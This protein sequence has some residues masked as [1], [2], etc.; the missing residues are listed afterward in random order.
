M[1]IHFETGSFF[2]EFF[3]ARRYSE[4]VTI[5][6]FSVPMTPANKLKN[7]EYGVTYADLSRQMEPSKNILRIKVVPYESK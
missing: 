3:V 5:L 7:T 4:K 6:S 1:S 2:D